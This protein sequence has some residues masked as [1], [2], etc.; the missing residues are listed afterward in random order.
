MSITTGYMKYYDGII[1][2][3]FIKDVASSVVVGG[4]YNKIMKYFDRNISAVGFG[5]YLDFIKRANKLEHDIDIF[6]LYNDN[7]DVKKVYQKVRSLI[8]EGIS[9]SAGKTVDKSLKIKRVINFSKN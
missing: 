5:I 8:D 3:G 7:D 4:Q 2:K 9:V 6:I 1:F